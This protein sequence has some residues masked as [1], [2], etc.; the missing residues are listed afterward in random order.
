LCLYIIVYMYKLM[1]AYLQDELEKIKES[2]EKLQTTIN[3]MSMSVY[4]CACISLYIM[5]ILVSVYL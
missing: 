2:Q 5:Y 4:L 3:K 1:S